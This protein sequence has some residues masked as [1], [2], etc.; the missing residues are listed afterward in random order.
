MEWFNI[1]KLWTFATQ[2]DAVSR[3]NKGRMLPSAGVTSPDVIPD[4]RADGSFWG[5]GR[6]QVIRLRDSTDFIDLSSVTNRQSRYKEYER[7]RNTVEIETALDVYADEMCVGGNTI[8]MTPTGPVTIEKLAETRKPNEMFMVYSYDFSKRDYTIAWAYHPRKIGK[9]KTVEIVFSDGS[10]LV[11]T[12]DHRVLLRNG[13]WIE[14]QD[15]QYKNRVMAFYRVTPKMKERETHNNIYHRPFRIFT[16]NEGFKSERQLLDEYRFE[17]KTAYGEKVDQILKCIQHG[18][19][20][21]QIEDYTGTSWASSDYILEGEGLSIKTLDAMHK[22]MPDYKWVVSVDEGEEIDV[23][24][25]SVKQHENFCTDSAVV[26]NCQMG[27]N[28]HVFDIKVKNPDI[29]EELEHL[30]FHP[31]MLNVDAKMFSWSKNLLIFGDFFFELVIDPENP[32]DGIMRIQE[33]PADSVYRIETIKGRVI[34]FQQSKGGP[35]YEALSKV[36]VTR[37]TDLELMQ[38]TAIRFSPSQIVH[39]RIGDERRTY[40]PYGVSIIEPARGPAHLL[41]LVEDAGVANRVSR[42]PERRVFYID[43]GGLPPFKAEMVMQRIQDSLRKKKTFNNR[44]NGGVGGASGVDER[45]QPVGQDEDIFVP[46]R[47]NTNTRVETL[48]GANN[49][50]QIEDLKYFREKVF[51]ALKFPKWYMAQEDPG[52]TKDNLSNLSME[53]C[54]HVERLQ[55]SVADGMTQ[56]A[57]RHLELRGYPAELYDDLRIKMT[58]PYPIKEIKNN[59]ITDAI[60]N[61]AMAVFGSQLLSHYDVLTKILKMDEN[62]AKEIVARK[63]AEKLNDLNLQMMATNPELMGVVAKTDNNPQMGTDANGP[64]PDLGQMDQGGEQQPQQQGEE[65]NAQDT[66]GSPP[67]AETFKFPEPSEEDIKRFDLG[68]IDYSSGIDAED[69]DVGELD[70]EPM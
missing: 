30:F 60:Y 27:D 1:L 32:S 40:Y 18:L 50:N 21:R 43:V 58:Q 52:T 28:G 31:Q 8:V 10:T 45:F 66:Y 4:V 3:K 57:L 5:G 24:D 54:H 7:L 59:E 26:H 15:L 55:M 16:Y 29:K 49:L 35:D 56:I 62:E 9:K 53:I 63:N 46:I 11:C 48:P 47:P 33:L 38:S 64:N 22:S 70:D 12:H 36:D 65:T 2:P 69:I 44:A 68:I 17:K 23:Y 37:A 13:N 19:T 51:L 41:R 14:A 25:M 39:M 34:E 67:Q 20:T 42:A 61:R 6:G